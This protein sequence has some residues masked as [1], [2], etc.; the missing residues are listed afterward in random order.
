MY[1][2]IHDDVFANEGNLFAIGFQEFLQDRGSTRRTAELDTL[3]RIHQLNRQDMIQVVHILKSFVAALA[4]I[5]TW[6]SCPLL[7]TIESLLA[8]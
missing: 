4:P 7:D 6:S 5:L 2:G 8:A 1:F 3:C